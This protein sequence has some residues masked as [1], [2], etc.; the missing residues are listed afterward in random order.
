MEARGAAVV[1]GAGKGLGREIARRLV[2]RGHVVAVTDVDEA[3]AAAVAAELGERAWATALQV[4][5]ADACRAVAR[6]AAA[7]AGGA[8]GLDVWVNN[9]G[10]LR[11]GPSWELS[12]EER[13]LIL[14]V[15]A[16]G[17]M[18]GT[19]AALEL[20]RP[21]NRGHVVNIVS[22]AGLVGA[23]GEAVYAAS[24]HAALGF[25]IATLADLRLAGID[26]V[27]ISSLCPDGMWTPMLFDK[28]GDPSAAASW[29]G[30]MLLPEDVADEAVALLDRPRPVRA[31]PRWRGGV[32]RVFDALPR[33][34]V[35]AIPAVMADARRKQRRFAKR[36]ARDQRYAQR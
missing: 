31:L 13:R 3:A 29:S 18:N 20:M 27:H 23:P 11:T 2:A 14:D 26:G 30:V 7:R 5:D 32:V 36:A 25:G 8:A 12:D 16:H 35:A 19:L 6:D 24:K 9:A 22:L 1:T 15:N 17:T 28:V 4:T 33:I 10:I 21:A 34:A